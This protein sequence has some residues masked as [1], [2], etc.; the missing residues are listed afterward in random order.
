MNEIL[1]AKVESDDTEFYCSVQIGKGVRL[2]PSIM[3]GFIKELQSRLEDIL[4]QIPENHEGC[5]D[6]LVGNQ[7]EAITHH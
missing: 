2:H 1:T 5:P 7:A 6:V 3:R 4:T